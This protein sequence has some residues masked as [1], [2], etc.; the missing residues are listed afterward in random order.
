M[1]KCRGLWALGQ[2]AGALGE[3]ARGKVRGE[4]GALIRHRG[5]GYTEE[6]CDT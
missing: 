2:D 4:P 6:P 3:D 1:E 5:Q